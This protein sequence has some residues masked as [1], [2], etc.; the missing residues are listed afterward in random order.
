LS[1]RSHPLINVLNTG[2]TIK[3]KKHRVR[4]IILWTIGILLL[5]II[6]GSFIVYNNLN[7]ILT[8]ALNKSFNSNIASDVYELKFEKLSVNL[9]AGDVKVY[10]VKLQPREKPLQD[11]PYINSSFR[12]T[13][14][15]MILKN[16]ELMTLIRSDKLVLEQ[17]EITEPEVDLRIEDQIP[18]FLPF[19]D[20][21][22]SANKEKKNN[23][24]SIESFSL[25]E[26]SMIDA[27]FHVTNLA[28]EREFNI[29][30]LSISLR[31]IL[32]DQQA[33]KDLVSYKNFE[34]S[35]GEFTGDLQQKSRHISFKDFKINIDSL[36]VE[37]TLD[38]AI[39]HFAD[40]STGLKDLD[41]QTKDSLFRLTVQ[42]FD[43][44]YK[45]RSIKLSDVSFKPNVSEA[46]M[47]ARFKYQNT[48]FSG[49]VGTLN[50]LGVNFDSLIY[51]KKIFI[52]E[53]VLDKVS[54]SIFK[55]KSKPID[56]GKFPEYLGQSI[57]A[58]PS[59]VL[60][61][62]VS[63]TNINL[64]NRE[65]NPDGSYATANINRA[66]VDV[67][68]ITNLSSNDVLM[69]NANAYIE[70]KAH[71]NLSLGF[72]Y[73]EPRFS[74]DGR[75]EK[76]NLPGLNPLVEAY[77]PASIHKGVLDEMTF[78]GNVYRT[79]STG[80][81]KFLYHDLDLEIELEGKAKW[82]SD[83]LAFGANTLLPSANPAP[84]LPPRVVSFKAER[85]MHKSFVNITI[86]SL[87]AGL[88]ETVLMS[89]ENK[90]AFRQEK[91]EAK[92]EA[93]KKA[94]EEKKKNKQ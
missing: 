73:V 19:K 32:I 46:T 28:K 86:K 76:F 11:Y 49:T 58:I 59:P 64:V 1:L 60:I 57:K 21:T 83:V 45:D 26:F 62:K 67:K 80:T 16:V 4:K 72:S 75:I 35:I 17:I 40:F 13:T 56:P 9:L 20:T 85:D 25:K 5:I 7:R 77:T 69:L 53:V 82:K 47:Q 94:K 90:K 84:G 2:S 27:A 23:K 34:L 92:K 30:K 29:R 48:Q 8:D 22:A 43:L 14:Q 41:I 44:S 70:N 87:L 39:Y 12:L 61:K 55:D 63:G 71:F 89:K 93:R 3:K 79:G 51:R 66:S 81:M 36:R 74:F 33:G 24:K 65:R 54:A 37:Q 18:I 68:N 38:T 6:A 50:L 88:K 31:D 52:N 42:S 91:K 10:N 15:K 78:S